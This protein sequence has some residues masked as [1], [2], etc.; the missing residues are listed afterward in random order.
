MYPSSL[1]SVLFWSTY[2]YVH[3]I[4]RRRQLLNVYVYN[5][6][7][8]GEKSIVFIIRWEFFFSNKQYFSATY[9]GKTAS[10]P[11]TKF[12]IQFPSDWHDQE[13]HVWSSCTAPWLEKHLIPTVKHGGAGVKIWAYFKTYNEHHFIQKYLRQMFSKMGHKYIM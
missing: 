5:K 10:K 1:F 9:N 2:V 13:G 6:W 4:P 11:T 7:E 12:L 8:K 3:I